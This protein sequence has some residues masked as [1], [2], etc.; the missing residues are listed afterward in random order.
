[1]GTVQDPRLPRGKGGDAC[2]KVVRDATR[3]RTSWRSSRW[4]PC[5]PWRTFSRR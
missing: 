3:M 5:T 1:V 2:L 4:W